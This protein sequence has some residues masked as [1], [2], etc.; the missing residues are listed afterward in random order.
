MMIATLMLLQEPIAVWQAW[1]VGDR[2]LQLS[3]EI[4][5]A[6][7]VYLVSLFVLGLRFSHLKHHV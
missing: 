7:T 6:M 4:P 2:I 5:L 1:S 3:I